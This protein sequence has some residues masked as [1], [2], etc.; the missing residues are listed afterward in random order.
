MHIKKL[1]A[2]II[3]AVLFVLY[4]TGLLVLWTNFYLPL[5]AKVIGMVILLALA[6][7]MVFVL[8]ER[9]QEIRS[10]EEDD[11]SKY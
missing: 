4:L 7:V 6:A 3:I 9:I 1:I 5:P 11:L 10:G 8:V 2:P